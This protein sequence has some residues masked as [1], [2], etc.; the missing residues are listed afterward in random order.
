MPE[1]GMKEDCVAE[2]LKK[3]DLHQIG[4]LKESEDLMQIGV[5]LPSYTTG[6]VDQITEWDKGH[7]LRASTNVSVRFFAKLHDSMKSNHCRA[8]LKERFSKFSHI[9]EELH[10]LIYEAHCRS[11]LFAIDRASPQNQRIKGDLMYHLEGAL[12]GCFGIGDD[13][14]GP[15]KDTSDSDSEIDER[16][17]TTVSKE[18]LM[19]L[20]YYTP[21]S[22]RVAWKLA[23]M[24]I[25][26]YLKCRNPPSP[27]DF[28]DNIYLARCSVEGEQ[29][30][31]EQLNLSV[32]EMLRI[33]N[34]LRFVAFLGKKDLAN[35]K[36]T[37]PSMDDI[38]ELIGDE[39]PGNGV[40]SLQ[41]ALY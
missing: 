27:H 12:H 14:S 18:C 11:K 29:G 9:S 41:A 33:R 30:W 39:G 32:S 31:N 5:T 10:E 15:G 34:A 1:S 3:L 37:R 36:I 26:H 2:V 28:P 16:H 17:L 40:L 6:F 7:K 22:V 8:I 24:P 38:A 4:D 21:S 20:P 23:N 35:S 25:P 13:T 19:C